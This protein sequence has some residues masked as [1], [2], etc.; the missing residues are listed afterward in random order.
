[1][2]VCLSV[3]VLNMRHGAE[4]KCKIP[5]WLHYIGFRVLGK[6]FGIGEN[7]LKRTISVRRDTT[8]DLLSQSLVDRVEAD[9]QFDQLIQQWSQLSNVFDRFF[10]CFIFFL[11]TTSTVLLLILCPR[12]SERTFDSQ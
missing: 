12:F 6:V 10:F 3:I 9:Q 4:H 8:R 5:D 1:M 2:S 11:T 7:E